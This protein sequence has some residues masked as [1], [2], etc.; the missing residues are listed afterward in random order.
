LSA[1]AKI[2]P[3]SGIINRGLYQGLS[4]NTPWVTK[5]SIKPPPREIE[6]NVREKS[7]R[8]FFPTMRR[9]IRLEAINITARIS[10]MIIQLSD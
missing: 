2:I 8:R 6:I 7:R 4:C 5:T 9:A 10:E 3:A 1:F